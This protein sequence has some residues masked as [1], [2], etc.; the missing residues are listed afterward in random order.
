MLVDR[1]GE[2]APGLEGGGGGARP[3]GR[4]S[5]RLVSECCLCGWSLIVVS[6]DS[7]VTPA[8]ATSRPPLARAAR[9]AVGMFM[10]PGRPAFIFC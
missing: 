8:P 6:R 2:E 10:K 7:Y 9:A 3:C 4:E 5:P 1:R